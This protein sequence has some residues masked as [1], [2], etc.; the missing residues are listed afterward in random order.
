MSSARLAGIAH[1][2][3][4]QDQAVEDREQGRV[5]ADAE[6]ERQ[7]GDGRDA[8]IPRALAEAIP[9]VPRELIHQKV[10]AHSCL[11]AL[12]LVGKR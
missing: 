10:P 2:Q 3:R 4:A 1:G 6:R 11:L 8:R 12:I 9:Q 5:R 7:H